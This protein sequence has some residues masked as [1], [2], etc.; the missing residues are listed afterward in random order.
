MALSNKTLTPAGTFVGAGG[1]AF[2]SAQYAEDLHDAVAAIETT[3][4]DITSV[5]AG[6]GMTGGGASGAVTL[7]VIA[8]DNIAVTA[9]A[10]ALATNV[11]VAGTLGVTGVTTLA[12]DAVVRSPSG[13]AVTIVEPNLTLSDTTP[14]EANVGGCLV[15]AGNYTGTTATGGAL[16]KCA[17]ASGVD[18]EY[19]FDLVL[20]TRTNGIGDVTEA[21]RL[22]AAQ[23]A[24]VAGE[25][26]VNGAL[27]H[28]GDEV[29]F[30]GTTPTAKQTSVAVSAEAIHAALVNLGLIGV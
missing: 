11:V 25:L 19:G 4:A 18:E 8:G 5:V 24:I 27:N 12:A 13:S 16:L 1:N 21:L 23:G 3:A 28:D 17:K 7:N 9:D 14:M 30:Y 29:G 20:A 10:V 26:E 6:D 22:T 2:D 15:F